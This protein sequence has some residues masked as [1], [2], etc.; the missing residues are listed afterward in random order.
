M[1][2]ALSTLAVVVSCNTGQ[3]PLFS[4]GLVADI[5]AAQKPDGETE[6]RRQ[7]YSTATGRFSEAVTDW[8][9]RRVDCVLSLGDTLSVAP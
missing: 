9:G 6:G 1:G 7:R 3:S 8:V 4:I 5:Q 2:G